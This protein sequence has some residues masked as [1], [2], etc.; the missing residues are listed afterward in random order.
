MYV[1]H[2]VIMHNE[3]AVPNVR[4]AKL[5]CFTVTDKDQCQSCKKL[6]FLNILSVKMAFYC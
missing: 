5:S 3:N 6:C 2:Y 4:I 1:L